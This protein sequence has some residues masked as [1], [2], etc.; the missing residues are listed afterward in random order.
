MPPIMEE[1]N[2]EDSSSNFQDLY[3]Y[4]QQFQGGF[5]SDDSAQANVEIDGL[6]YSIPQNFSIRPPFTAEI[7]AM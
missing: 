6:D 1:D 7:V 4:N 2:L 3:F 5:A